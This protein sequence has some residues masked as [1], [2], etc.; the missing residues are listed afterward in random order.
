MAKVDP[1]PPF[2]SNIAVQDFAERRGIK[3][4]S[5]DVVLFNDE[6]VP[7]EVMYSRIFEK[8]GALELIDLSR[9]EIINGQFVKNSPITNSQS[10]N[11]FY[12]SLNIFKA[13]GDIRSTFDN[14]G[15]KFLNYIPANGTGPI[16]DPL[17]GERSIVYVSD[18]TGG[19]VVDVTNLTLNERVQIQVLQ[20]GKILG[21]RIEVEES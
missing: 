21:D 16:L 10:I 19:I 1:V 9:S 5:P 7:V 17:S 18:E 14:F 15:I 2:I 8:I 4:A 13:P 20:D 6:E 12:N 3:S 11:F